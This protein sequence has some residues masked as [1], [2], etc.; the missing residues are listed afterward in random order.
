MQCNCLL[1]LSFS[2][3][4]GLIG[5]PASLPLASLAVPSHRSA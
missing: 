2:V 4:P 5:D 3:I 1:E